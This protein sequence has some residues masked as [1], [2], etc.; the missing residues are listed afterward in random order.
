MKSVT[1]EQYKQENKKA[2]KILV[3]IT[4]A[5]GVF[6]GII[7]VIASIHGAQGLAETFSKMLHQFLF[8]IGPWAVILSTLIGIL[9]GLHMYK[10]AQK[11]YENSLPAND[12]EIEEEIFMEIDHKVGKGIFIISI[13]MILSFMFYAIVVS[14]IDRYAE[15]SPAL[16]VVSFIVFIVSMFG[17]GKIQQM[18]IDFTKVLYPQKNGSVYDI[19]FSEKWEESCDELEKLM[20]YKAAYKAYKTTNMVCCICLVAMIL[21]SFFFHYGPLPA[22]LVGVIWLVHMVAYYLEGMKLEKEKVNQ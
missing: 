8:I 15:E 1:K 13:M 5:S 19:K 9:G 10:S 12:D 20:I 2:L 21:L 3:P 14:Y 7:G 17:S 18:L 4:I 6:G 16:L 22:M 11:D